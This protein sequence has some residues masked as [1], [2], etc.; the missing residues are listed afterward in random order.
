MMV[1][2]TLFHEIRLSITKV[3]NDFRKVCEPNQTV[4][5]IG[6]FEGGCPNLPDV[7][8]YLTLPYKACNAY[9]LVDVS[10]LSVNESLPINPIH[11]T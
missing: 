8:S 1:F 6:H 7:Q 4:H 11:L 9:I 5:V 2:C 3:M 10:M